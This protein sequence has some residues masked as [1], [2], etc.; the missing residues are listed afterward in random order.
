MS[1]P[2]SLLRH[3]FLHGLQQINLLC[4][5]YICC[6]WYNIGC[7]GT[8]ALAPGEPSSLPSSH[9]LVFVRL[10]LS[11]LPYFSLS[12]L[13]L[14]NIVS[15]FHKY[16]LTE[17]Q[18]ALLIGWALASGESL[19]ELLELAHGLFSQRSSLQ[20]LLRYQN[21]ATYAQYNLAVEI[22]VFY[23]LKMFKM[24]VYTEQSYVAAAL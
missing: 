5:K 12:Q 1:A 9:T 10:F 7:R 13:L 6:I 4:S 11:F 8:S 19:L 15:P 2:V 23:F 17:A 18:I 14:W 20:P 3:Q 24:K 16:V 21:L 22:R